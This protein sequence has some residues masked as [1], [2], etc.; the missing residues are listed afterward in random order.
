MYGYR[1]GMV[2]YIE[3]ILPP[4]QT[5]M[6]EKTNEKKKKKYLYIHMSKQYDST[7]PIEKK[8]SLDIYT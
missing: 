2:C 7:I 1:N 4:E 5:Q 3:C 6:V 8:R